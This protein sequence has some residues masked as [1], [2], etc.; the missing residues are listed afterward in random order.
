VFFTEWDDFTHV[1]ADHWASPQGWTIIGGYD[2]GTPFENEYIAADTDAW[3]PEWSNGESTAEVFINYGLPMIQATINLENGWRRPHERLKP[4]AG[5]DGNQ[6]TLLIFTKI[7]HASKTENR[8]AN[9]R[10]SA[11]DESEYQLSR[12]VTINLT[13]RL[14]Q[15]CGQ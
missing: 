8:P 9:H 6:T 4:M 14:T 15:G 7:F 12:P 1:F 11:G 10:G 2:V 5:S 13:T 3:V